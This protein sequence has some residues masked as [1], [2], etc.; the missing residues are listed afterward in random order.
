MFH[1][2]LCGKKNK[3]SSGNCFSVY[4]SFRLF[5]IA[6]R[7]SIAF[8]LVGLHRSLTSLYLGRQVCGFGSH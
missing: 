7:L 2:S 1:E 8:M 4:T 3:N 5:Q 6:L